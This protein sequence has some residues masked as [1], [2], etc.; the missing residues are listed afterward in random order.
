MR[1]RKLI[2]VK[3]NIASSIIGHIKRLSYGVERKTLN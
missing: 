3:R 2:S 1:I